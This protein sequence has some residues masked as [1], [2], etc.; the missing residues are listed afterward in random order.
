MYTGV[1]DDSKHINS[2]FFVFINLVLSY[3]IFSMPNN[4]FMIR[5]A[6]KT[7]IT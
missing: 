7:L 4:F 6:N 3:S 1:R 5:T 2:N